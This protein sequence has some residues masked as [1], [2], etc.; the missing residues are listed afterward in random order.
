MTASYRF[1][2]RGRVQGVGFRAAASE[3][4]HRLQLRGWVRNRPDGGVEGLIAGP[5]D[6]LQRFREWLKHGPPAARVDAVD[7]QPSD[8]LLQTQ[9]FGIRR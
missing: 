4:G 1:T 7:W 8:E 9:E 3:T 6:E 2:V 5:D